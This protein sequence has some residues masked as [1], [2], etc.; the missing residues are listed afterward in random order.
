[1]QDW[2][3]DTHESRGRKI[4]TNIIRRLVVVWMVETRTTA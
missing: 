1:V 4:A 2:D 3:W